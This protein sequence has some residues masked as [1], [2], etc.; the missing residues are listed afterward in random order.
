MIVIFVVSGL[1]LDSISECL[2]YKAGCAMRLPVWEMAAMAGVAFAI[3]SCTLCM[4]GL[5]AVHFSG[6]W[7]DTAPGMA[8]F[9]FWVQSSAKGAGA[10][11]NQRYGPCASV[12]SGRLQGKAMPMRPCSRCLL[13]SVD[14]CPLARLP[15]CLASA[16]GLAV[17]CVVP[18]TLSSGV[19]MVTQAKAFVTSCQ[20]WQ[21]WQEWQE[22]HR[23]MC[24]WPSC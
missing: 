24:P 6:A 1:C 20:Q 4:A 22:W 11:M 12:A 9:A 21:K 8:D 23:A 16:Q 17:F 3:F 7:R 18:T 5:S 19:T 2:Q 15:A 14:S 10:A 13:T